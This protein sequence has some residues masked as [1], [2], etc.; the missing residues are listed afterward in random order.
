[1]TG[2]PAT[3]AARTEAPSAQPANNP[4]PVAAHAPETTRK[5][6]HVWV[7][8]LNKLIQIVALFVAGFWA[9][10][11]FQQTVVPS[12][13]PKFPVD[14][15]IHWAKVPGTDACQARFEVVVKN[16]GQVA[17]DIQSVKVTGW[18][19]D[20]KKSKLIPDNAMLPAHLDPAIT[21]AGRDD[22]AKEFDTGNGDPVQP[23]LIDHY[24]PGVQSTSTAN[25]F[26]KR[27]PQTL[28]IM[29]A[30][31]KG[32]RRS[33]F[34][35][36]AKKLPIENYSYAIDQVCGAN[37]DENAPPT[38]SAPPSPKAQSASR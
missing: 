28:V 6:F 2:E 36:F 19:V 27:R 37:W 35:P 5:D 22:G 26:F 11:V 23:D 30:E 15:A 20:L 29:L 3:Q 24:P 38:T 7:D 21:E 13:E 16:D 33:S 18:T 32:E 8:T 31:L 25:F 34:L 9:W 14:T 1:M 4:Q 17:F 10:K 12:L